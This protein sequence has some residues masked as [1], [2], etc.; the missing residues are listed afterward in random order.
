MPKRSFDGVV[1]NHHKRRYD[2]SGVDKKGKKMRELEYWHHG[3]H[4]REERAEHMALMYIY[5]LN[6]KSK[7]NN[8]VV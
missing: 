3:I 1:I 7:T 2:E 6:K 5:L 4:T 8:N